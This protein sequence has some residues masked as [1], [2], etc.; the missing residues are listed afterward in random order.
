MDFPI[1]DLMSEQSSEEWILEHFH[2]AGLRC[3]HCGAAWA[4]ASEFRT[5]RR[6]QL[7]VYR[8]RTCHGIYN[9]P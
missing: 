6:S 4:K 7:T 3:P 8:C 2:P 1:V 9:L 5:T